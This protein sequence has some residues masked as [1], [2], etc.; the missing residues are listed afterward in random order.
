MI[1]WS[2]SDLPD[3]DKDDN[4]GEDEPQLGP[5]CPGY[6]AGCI[7]RGCSA[8]PARGSLSLL[9]S[10]EFLRLRGRHAIS[11]LRS[12]FVRLP[13]IAHAQDSVAP[14]NLRSKPRPTKASG[15]TRRVFFR[16]AGRMPPAAN[17][18]DDMVVMVMSMPMNDD[19]HNDG[20]GY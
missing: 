16:A 1:T 11:W 6:R 9:R 20:G 10:K 7:G 8:M 2:P 13:N 5:L 14:R 17:Y 19:N 15:G 18:S 4:K 3:E 12:V